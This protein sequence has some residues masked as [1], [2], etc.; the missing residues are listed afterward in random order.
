M[1]TSNSSIGE[2]E[3]GKKRENNTEYFDVAGDDLAR[4]HRHTGKH[5][6]HSHTR[7]AHTIEALVQ[8]LI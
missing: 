2:E 3:E 4:T 5:T 6:I 1:R 7:N 8:W